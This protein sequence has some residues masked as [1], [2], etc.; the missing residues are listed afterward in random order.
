MEFRANLG[1]FYFWD[2]DG[3]GVNPIAMYQCVS[4]AEG[5]E[6]TAANTAGV[7]GGYGDIVVPTPTGS[8]GGITTATRRIVGVTQA[9]QWSGQLVT[10]AMA[11]SISWVQANAALGGSSANFMHCVS[12]TTRTS[13][14]TPFTNNSEMLLPY[15]PRG[16]ITYN[17][18]MIDDPA[19]T[20]ATGAGTNVQYFPL[21]WALDTATAQYDL[22]AVEL[23]CGSIYG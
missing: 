8:L 9:S 16:T 20:P 23:F 10:V 14:Q 22:V 1:S 7:P 5:A 11:G 15:D 3:S 4:L 12:K 2:T 6:I 17:L 19:I 18:A 13:A 21:G